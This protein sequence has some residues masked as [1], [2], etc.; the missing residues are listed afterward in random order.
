MPTRRPRG[1]SLSKSAA[2]AEVVGDGGD[3]KKRGREVGRRKECEKIILRR[4]QQHCSRPR[5]PPLQPRRS[6][7]RVEDEGKDDAEGAAAEQGGCQ[8]HEP[9]VGSGSSSLLTVILF[10]LWLEWLWDMM[11]L[12]EMLLH[13]LAT[14][15]T[16][17][18]EGRRAPGARGALGLQYPEGRGAS[19][20]LGV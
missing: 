6:G 18:P 20:A 5:R 19:W 11:F 13:L 3:L 2:K 4:D 16:Q 10:R 1:G 17:H 7:G 14:V 9:V 15:P 12:S 8:E